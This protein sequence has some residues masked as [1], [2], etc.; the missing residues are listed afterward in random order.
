MVRTILCALMSLG[1]AVSAAAQEID[2][3]VTDY[4]APQTGAV[5]AWGD[6]PTSVIRL[7]AT[8][9][10]YE[11]FTFS[12]R[13]RERLEQ[14]FIKPGGPL[15]GAKG[16]IDA[17]NIVVAGIEDYHGGEYNALAPLGNP[18]DMAAWSRELFWTTVHV[19][20]DA[21]PGPY[22]G[23]IVVTSKDRRVAAIALTVEVLPFRLEEP[24][25]ALGFNYSSPKDPAKLA[26]HLRDMREHGMTSVGPLYN[27]HLPVNDQDTAEIGQFIEAYKAAGFTK[28]LYFASPMDLM[29]SLAGYGPVDS[30]RFQRKYLNTMRLI[31]AE[32]QK[33][34][35]PVIFSI[36]D[37]LTNRALPG[38]K[39]GEQLARL[40]FEELPEIPTTS[41]MNGYLE[42][43]TMA[44]YLDAATFNNGWDGIDHHNKGRRL[45]NR[46]FIEEVRKLGAIPWFVNG[47]EGR[48][49]YGFF[50]WKM[51]KYGVQ[52]KIEWY[53]NLGKNDK[54]SVVRLDG[55]RVTPTI[56]YEKSREGVDDLKCV[57]KLESLIADATKAGRGQSDAV[58]RAE[59]VVKELGDSII[60]N[61][62][63]YT[64]GG[65]QWP[66]ARFHQW[67][68]RVIDA[69]LAL[70]AK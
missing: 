69:I 28:T 39:F 37:E 4:M 23:E 58:R 2:L 42:V 15:V 55:D 17:S 54:G 8:P 30:Q 45:I 12:F 26:I 63:A 16:R 13:P 47:G 41:D 25:Y 19:P 44:P 29:F 67:R 49:P 52:G 35:V 51:A 48:F 10:E 34:D 70:S 59:T 1:L 31:F 57:L 36:A 64:D 27:F 18:W 53:Y 6:R 62:T 60:D 50:F 3:Y 61:W 65:E 5:A 32:T 38:I 24:P 9:G 14:V 11:P 22:S 46:E 7:R 40:C 66:P 20:A 56:A 68:E 21:A 33:H 43:T